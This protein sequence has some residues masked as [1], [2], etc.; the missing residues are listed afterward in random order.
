SDVF[1][2]EHIK[3]KDLRAIK[4]IRKD[5]ILH[6]NLLKEAYILKNLRHSCI[7]IIYDFEEDDHYSYIIEQYIKGQSLQ[8]FLG[9]WVGKVKESTI[10]EIGIQI[11]DLLQ[12]LY[13]LENPILYLDLQPNNIIISE[14]KVKLIDFGAS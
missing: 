13:S 1:L 14:E 11:C 8:Q 4:R 6:G 7:P 12:Y 9:Q 5:H 3:L 2:A 10:V